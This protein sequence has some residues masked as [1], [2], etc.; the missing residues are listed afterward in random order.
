M[1]Q[2]ESRGQ[3]PG[4]GHLGYPTG[5]F[6]GEMG[7]VEGSGVAADALPAFGFSLTVYANGRN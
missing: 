3:E 6:T 5:G 2:R 4:L 7:A 1:A